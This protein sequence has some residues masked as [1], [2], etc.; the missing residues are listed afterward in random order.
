MFI[1]ISQILYFESIF[2][3]HLQF[4]ITTALHY[5]IAEITTCYQDEYL[6]FLCITAHMQVQMYDLAHLTQWLH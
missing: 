3:E 4:M 1:I 6:Y 2:Y 5:L